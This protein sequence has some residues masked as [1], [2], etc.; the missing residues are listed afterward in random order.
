MRMPTANIEAVF[1]ATPLQQ[2]LLYHSLLGDDG[3]VYV[4]QQVIDL[5]GELDVEAFRACWRRVAARRQILR[6]SFHWKRTEQP[7]LERGV[8]KAARYPVAQRASLPRPGGRDRA[9]R[10]RSTRR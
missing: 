7:L 5:R 10:A 6:S 8:S 9:G 2:G 3:G 1:P 4:T